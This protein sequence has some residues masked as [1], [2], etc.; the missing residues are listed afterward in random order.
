M[1]Q[2]VG[3]MF[4]GEGRKKNARIKTSSLALPCDGLDM[5][6]FTSQLDCLLCQYSWYIVCRFDLVMNHSRRNIC[7]RRYKYLCK[8]SHEGSD[9]ISH[10]I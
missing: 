10:R 3:S 1:V 4:F 5:G 8:E 6:S 7:D 2:M 9:S